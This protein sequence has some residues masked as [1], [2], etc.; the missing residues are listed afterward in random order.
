MFNGNEA[1]EH[2]NK[3]RYDFMIVDI[4]I[5]GLDGFSLVKEVR[6]TNSEIPIVFLTAK[7]LQS[8]IKKDL[9]WVLTITS[10]NLSIWM[11]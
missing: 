8:D 1:L 3:E 5:P 4:M 9:I 11:S 10:S 7:S 2:F 6:K